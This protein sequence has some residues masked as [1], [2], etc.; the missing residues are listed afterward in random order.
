LAILLTGL[1]GWLIF[2]L[3]ERE[4]PA[5]ALPALLVWL[6]NP[7]VL[8]SSALGAHN[9]GLMLVLLLAAFLAAQRK[10]WVWAFL[11]LGLATQVKLTA[12]IW[13]P[14]LGLWL[15]RQIGFRRALL[16][17]MGGA[18]FLLPISSLL[19]QPLGG[20]ETL[21]RMLSERVLYV[22]NS[23]SQFIDRLLPLLGYRLPKEFVLFWIIRVP[24]YL[25]ATVGVAIPAWLIWRKRLA[26][27][28]VHPQLWALA[29]VASLLYLTL[30]SFWFQHWYVVW[31]ILPAA[32]LPWSRFTRRVL[33]FVCFGPLAANIVAETLS[34]LP[35][36]II[37]VIG[38]TGLVVAM[39]WLPGVVAGGVVWWTGRKDGKPKNPFVYTD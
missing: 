15:W 17:G 18:L 36:M 10:G 31:A 9:D 38:L 16:A 26:A 37:S 23:P 7:A 20:W 33:P 28:G 8:L 2:I 35:V 1:A 19:Y 14:V 6:W 11:L 27:W 5:W 4:H 22:A 29:L 39:I 34:Q 3:V 24:S 21:P 32:L 25:F 30:G 13:M 12:L